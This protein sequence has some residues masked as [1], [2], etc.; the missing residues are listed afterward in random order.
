MNYRERILAASRGQ[1]TDKMPFF[2]F[3]RHC[4]TGRAERE[5]RNRGMGI[6]A[7][8]GDNGAWPRERSVDLFRHRTYRYPKHSRIWAVVFR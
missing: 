7:E 4:Q 5:C 8:A 1:R 6:C 3:W 2:H